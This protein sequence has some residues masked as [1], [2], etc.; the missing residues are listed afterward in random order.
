MSQE[1]HTHTGMHTQACTH[2]FWNSGKDQ[3]KIN[4]WA[5]LQTNEK[6]V[7]KLTALKDMDI[8]TAES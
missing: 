7:R 4:S 2:T 3:T 5:D 8:I 1:N 6:C